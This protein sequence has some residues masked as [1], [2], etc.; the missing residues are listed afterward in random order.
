MKKAQLLLV[1]SNTDINA[2]INPTADESIKVKLHSIQWR[3]PHLSVADLER[4][5]L[6]K[7]MENY[8]ELS[9]P[10]R[11]RELHEYPL[12]TDSQTHTWNIIKT[13]SQ[14]E[15]PRFIIFGYQSA[16]KNMAAK[17]MSEFD[18]CGLTLN[19]S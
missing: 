5:K 3:V 7:C 10:F 19:F 16:R 1:R 11:S 17:R 4:L 15:K 6:I 2:I 8:T 13:S 14:L 18:H 9:V 12:L